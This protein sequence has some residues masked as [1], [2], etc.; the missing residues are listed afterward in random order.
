M[1]AAFAR[2]NQQ[3]AGDRCFRIEAFARRFGSES[4]LEADGRFV[5]QS[6]AHDVPLHLVRALNCQRFVNA[7]S[8]R[9]RLAVR[10]RLHDRN[11]ELLSSQTGGKR[12]KTEKTRASREL[13]AA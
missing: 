10:L 7:M 8:E 9:H 12:E 11:V 6:L 13:L 5:S 1:H 4:R 3:H 2:R